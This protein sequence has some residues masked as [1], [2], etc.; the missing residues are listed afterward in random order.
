MRPTGRSHLSTGD[1]I[2]IEERESDT[3]DVA[4]PTL[5]ALV[6]LEET[7]DRK[8]SRGGT[9]PAAG[10]RAGFEFNV[11][12]PSVGSMPEPSHRKARGD[13]DVVA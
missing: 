4:S 2:G 13:L 5:A 10:I 1:T 12:Q 8:T 11:P 6:G 3:E 7:F 9:H